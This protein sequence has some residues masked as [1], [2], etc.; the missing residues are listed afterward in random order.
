MADS[1]TRYSWEPQRVQRDFMDEPVPGNRFVH[2][3]TLHPLRLPGIPRPGVSHRST[4]AGRET[5]ARPFGPRRHQGRDPPHA[6][7]RVSLVRSWPCDTAQRARDPARG[8]IR[9]GF[10]A[11]QGTVQTMERY[12]QH[13]GEKGAL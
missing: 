4:L 10:L 13:A 1:R 9:E 6:P 7:R 11:A 5:R 2:E 12:T 8:G 3:V